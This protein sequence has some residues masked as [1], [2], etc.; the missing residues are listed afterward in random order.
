MKRGGHTFLCFLFFP[1]ADS[2]LLELRFAKQIKQ[3]REIKVMLFNSLSNNSDK[4]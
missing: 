4:L 1:R 2:L 3:L